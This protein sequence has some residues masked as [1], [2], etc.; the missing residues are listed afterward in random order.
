MKNRVIIKKENKNNAKDNLAFYLKNDQGE[1]WLFEQ[2]CTKGV[3]EYFKNGRA[4]REIIA[5]K[6]WGNNKRLNNTIARIPREIR[7]V[8]KY[9]IGEEYAA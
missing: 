3:Y 7:Y 6:K 2:E 8:T 5:F 1:F 4:E 9:V